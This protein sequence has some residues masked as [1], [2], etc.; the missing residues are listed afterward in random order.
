MLIISV[1]ILNIYSNVGLN[2]VLHPA[3]IKLICIL[4]ITIVLHD[5]GSSEVKSREALCAV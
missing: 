1:H 3:F 5:V 2:F 4:G